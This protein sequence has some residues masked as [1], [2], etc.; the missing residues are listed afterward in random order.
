MAD[1][2]TRP[3]MRTGQVARLAGVEPITIVRWAN[4]GRIECY[5]TV[6]G[7]RRFPVAEVAKLL[8]ALG[9]SHDL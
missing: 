7:D 5:R 8:D 6:G 9:V 2:E 1:I 4:A 3:A